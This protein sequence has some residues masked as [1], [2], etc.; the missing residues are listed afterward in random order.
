LKKE[1]EED[2]KQIRV[3]QQD[4]D[5]IREKFEENRE[6]IQKEKDQLLTEQMGVKEA[7]TREIFSMPGLAQI[8]EETVES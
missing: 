1:K 8:E 7:V 5:D 3:A 6:K 4:K 2:L